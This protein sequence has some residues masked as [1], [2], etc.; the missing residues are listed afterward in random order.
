MALIGYH[1][2]TSAKTERYS[3]LL[4]TILRAIGAGTLK[5]WDIHLAKATLLVNTQGSASGAGLA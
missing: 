1:A 3:G 4:K 2:P 5:H